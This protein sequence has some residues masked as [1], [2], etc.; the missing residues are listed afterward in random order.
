MQDVK[1]SIGEGKKKPK[2]RRES[3]MWKDQKD[4][5]SKKEESGMEILRDADPPS[6]IWQQ[7]PT[8]ARVHTHTH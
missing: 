3:M 1:T 7:S 4:N 5:L 8:Q 6:V 2:W